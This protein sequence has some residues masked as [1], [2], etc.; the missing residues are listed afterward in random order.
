[1]NNEIYGKNDSHCKYPIYDKEQ[2]N[3]LLAN[4]VNTSEVYNKQEIDELLNNI[5]ASN[6]A[7]GNQLPE[8]AEEGTIFLLWK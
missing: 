3:T 5:S 8:T 6:I 1:M 7:D 4:K 2:I